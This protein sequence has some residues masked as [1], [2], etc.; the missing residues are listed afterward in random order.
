MSCS[1]IQ[2]DAVHFLLAQKQGSVDLVFG[3]PPY[4]DL[5]LYLENGEDLGISRATDDWVRW[6]VKVYHAAQWACKGLV[7]F[8][9]AGRTQDFRWS[10]GPALLMAELHKQGFGVRNPP[11]FHRNG[12]SGSGGPD[13]LRSDYEWI[14]C[15]SRP[16]RLPW[17]DNVAYGK[18]PKFTPGG[19]MRYRMRNDQRQKRGP[20]KP[21]AKANPGNVLRF[22]VGGKH[23]GSAIAHDNEAP[24]PLGL[25][26]FFVK[27]FCPP[28]GVACDPFS[29]SGTT[30]HAAIVSGRHFSGC[31]LRNS[32]V[33]MATQRVSTLTALPQPV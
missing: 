30:A 28:G 31:D 22:T 12:I 8:V 5:R 6:M 18:P 17:S 32:Q 21:P 14:V 3:S 25:A 27:S 15:T 13:W 1:I 4:A 10:A 11:I 19:G 2:D 16:G 20:Y 9:V 23:M 29:G 7:A 26:E 24:M 33:E